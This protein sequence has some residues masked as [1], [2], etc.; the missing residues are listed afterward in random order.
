MA[1]RVPLLCI[2]V[3]LLASCG[4]QQSSP[5]VVGHWRLVA[6]AARDNTGGVSY[7]FGTNPDGQVTY[8]TAG[9]VYVLLFNPDRQTFASGDWLRGTDDEVRAA[10]EGSVA[11]YGKYSVDATAGTVTHHVLGSTYPNYIRTD[12]VRHYKLEGGR[13]TLTTAPFLLGE[14]TITAVNVFERID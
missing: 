9:N 8:D 14:K 2:L 7:T 5:P 1:L 4:Q 12:L 11:Y 6:Q 10:F 13:L 3:S